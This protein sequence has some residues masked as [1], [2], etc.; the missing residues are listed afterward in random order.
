MSTPDRKRTASV[1]SRRV[2]RALRV[3][4]RTDAPSVSLEGRQTA[5][6]HPDASAEVLLV[7]DPSRSQRRQ[8]LQAPWLHWQRAEAQSQAL[9]PGKTP[10]ER[11]CRFASVPWADRT[12]P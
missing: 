9:H 10:S 2:G 11:L 1:A 7:E 5:L 8:A 4:L 6:L 3:L 12:D